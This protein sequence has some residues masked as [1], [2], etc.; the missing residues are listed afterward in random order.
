MGSLSYRIESIYL[1]P[2]QSTLVYHIVRTVEVSVSTSV[3]VKRARLEEVEA[4]F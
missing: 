2:A 4:A 1:G 3:K